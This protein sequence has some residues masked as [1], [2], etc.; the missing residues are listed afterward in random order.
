VRNFSSVN[1]GRCR[2]F[3]TCT[4][5]PSFH[6]N[7]RS[8]VVQPSA[9]KTMPPLPDYVGFQGSVFCD[10]KL[11]QSDNVLEELIASIF[12]VKK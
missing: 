5:S 1:R 10:I 6:T 11:C 2:F 3:T 9:M 7:S 8:S 12:R 4:G